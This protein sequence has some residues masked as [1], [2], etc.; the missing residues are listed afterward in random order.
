MPNTITNLEF[1]LQEAEKDV[2]WALGLAQQNAETHGSIEGWLGIANQHIARRDRIL[3]AMILAEAS[4]Q[5][6]N[7]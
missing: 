6:T 7:A 1:K 2:E 5:V 4:K 3:I